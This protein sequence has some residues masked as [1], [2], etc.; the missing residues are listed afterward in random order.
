[1]EIVAIRI[2]RSPQRCNLLISHSFNHAVWKITKV[3][4][5]KGVNSIHI[6]VTVNIDLAVQ[7][8]PVI[9]VVDLVRVDLN[10]PMECFQDQSI[11]VW[12]N[13]N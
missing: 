4:L 7:I 3:K 11:L 13:L 10:Q 6:C 1:M 9:L 2:T 8:D 12:I 5:H